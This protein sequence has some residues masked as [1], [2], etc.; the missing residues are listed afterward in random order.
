[1]T[2]MIRVA[3]ASLM[4]LV[5]LPGLARAADTVIGPLVTKGKTHIL[6][7]VYVTRAMGVE[8]KAWLVV[9]VTDVPVDAASRHTARLTELAAAGKLHGVR[10][11]WSE[12]F[13]HLVAT[14]F[15]GAVEDN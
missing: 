12:G 14:P 8:S 3:A 11:I 7:Q 2:M 5:T 4:C 13:D 9:L 10:V 15:D 1:M 6:K